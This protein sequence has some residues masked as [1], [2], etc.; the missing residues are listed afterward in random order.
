MKAI[1]TTCA[2]IG[3]AGGS[4]AQTVPTA[5]DP[6][7]PV[8]TRDAANAPSEATKLTE[9][10]ARSRI[11]EMGYG[12]VTDLQMGEGGLWR[13]TAEKDGATVAVTVDGE[14]KVA[15]TAK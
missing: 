9:D 11:E 12:E 13:A 6:Q 7:E 5:T 8:V 10:Q 1:L 2:L 15:E 4:L 3:L 14:G